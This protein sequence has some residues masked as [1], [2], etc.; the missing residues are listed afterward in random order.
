[1]N[2]FLAGDNFRWAD[3]ALAMLANVIDWFIPP[4]IR[5]GDI[6]LL[7]RA[8]LAV[9]I[10]SLLILLAIAYAVILFLLDSPIGAAVLA[11]GAGMIAGGLFIM[12][13]TGSSFIAGNLITAT[14]FGVLTAL[15]CRLGGHGSIAIPWYIGVPVVALST[16]GGRSA[17]AWLA[18]TMM[19]LTVFFTLDQQGYQ[20]VNDLG[21]A[22]YKVLDFLS[23]IG[24]AILIFGLNLLHEM[25]KSQAFLELKRTKTILQREKDFSDCVIASMPG[26]FYLI[27]DEGQ[28]LRWNKN[29]EDVSG[30]TPEV[31]AKMRPLDFFQGKDRRSSLRVSKKPSRKDNLPERLVL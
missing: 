15:A 29:Y 28:V 14:F 2:H 18:A 4:R 12:R 23:W 1:M 13:Q 9:T 17:I 24:L 19:S 11:T 16:A 31:L 7:R 3:S 27:D 5:D 25:A 20:L 21:V 22:Q 8:R 30:Y 10:G 26:I 6:E